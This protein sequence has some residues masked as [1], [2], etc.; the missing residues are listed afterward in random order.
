[1]QLKL[2]FPVPL[3]AQYLGRVC[4]HLFVQPSPGSQ[5]KAGTTNDKTTMFG[6]VVWAF[7]L[8]GCGHLFCF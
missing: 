6:F 4:C 7:P 8:L 2:K 1:M 3:Y 5:V